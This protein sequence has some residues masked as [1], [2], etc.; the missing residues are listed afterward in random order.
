MAPASRTVVATAS[1]RAR[2]RRVDCSSSASEIS[3]GDSL[4]MLG[5]LECYNAVVATVGNEWATCGPTWAPA[6]VQVAS[7]ISPMDGTGKPR[8]FR[9]VVSVWRWI[10][11][12]LIAWAAPP[13]IARTARA[14]SWRDRRKREC[15]HLQ[16][17][18]QELLQE[19][20]PEAT[21]DSPTT[22]FSWFTDP[23]L[24]AALVTPTVFAYVIPE[25][26]VRKKD[27]E[28]VARY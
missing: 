20:F 9:S 7:G 6:S 22:P 8:M 21:V 1:A 3:A 24:A 28:Y 14:V 25:G 26:P 19:E 5:K 16:T 4:S 10:A 13:L 27:L 15:Q 11:L 18:V 2:S 23:E 17:R 12:L